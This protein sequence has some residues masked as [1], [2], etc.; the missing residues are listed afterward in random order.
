MRKHAGRLDV[1]RWRLAGPLALLISLPALAIDPNRAMSQYV[2]EHWGPER[3]FPSGPVYGIAQTTD[4]YLWIGT[5]AGMV[6]FDGLNFRLLQ[7]ARASQLSLE[8]PL[9]QTLGVTSGEAGDLQPKLLRVLQEQEFERLGSSRT[10]QVNVRVVAATNQD[11][12]Q[13]VEERRFRADLYYRLN[14]FPI[15]LPPLRDRSEDIPELAWHF[16]RKFSRRM[17]KEINHIPDEVLNVLALHDW[18]DNIRE[19]QNFI[20]R[21]MVMTQG[22]VLQ[23]PHREFKQLVKCPTPAAVRTL[24]DAERDHITEVLRQARGVVGGRDG[25]AA[26]LGVARTT[27]LYRM[28]KLGIRAS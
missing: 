24:A 6:R 18:P 17:N 12:R 8:Q 20:E 16:V 3:G 10:I 21:A 26:R 27:L 2:R 28:Q 14:V 11:L 9:G 22:H 23:L 13:L 5:E 25:A 7:K 4:G 19:M 15:S 1:T